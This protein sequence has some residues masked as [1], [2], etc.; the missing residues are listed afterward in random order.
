MHVSSGIR[1]HDRSVPSGEDISYLRPEGH[2][3]R[4]ATTPT[5]NFQKF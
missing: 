5:P 1:T 2:F 4:S 3:D